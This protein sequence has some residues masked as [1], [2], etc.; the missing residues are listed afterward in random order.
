[1]FYPVPS[2]VDRASNG[3]ILYWHLFENNPVNI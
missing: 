1:M 3:V 2:N